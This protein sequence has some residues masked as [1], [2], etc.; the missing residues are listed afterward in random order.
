ML[1]IPLSVIFY[2]V[3]IIAYFIER[4]YIIS[5]KIIAILGVPQHQ[6]NDRIMR[7]DA[8]LGEWTPLPGVPGGQHVSHRAHRAHR[9][10]LFFDRIY[11]L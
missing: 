5:G 1:F 7:L 3:Y 10:Q 6:W 2:R 11:S 4:C 8:L 9:E